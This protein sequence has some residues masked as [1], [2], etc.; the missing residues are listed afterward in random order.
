[1]NNKWHQ[2]DIP[3]K[4][5]T[6]VEVIDIREDE[7]NELETD[8]ETC[9]MCGNEKIRYVHILT[10]KLIKEAFRVGCVCAEKMTNDY[11][12]P[13]KREDE[14]KNCTNRRLNFLNKEWKINSNG[15][16]YLKYVGHYLLIYRDK[17]TDKFK[18]KID[19]VFGNKLF[20][21]LNQ[22]KIATFNGIEHF[23]ETGDWEYKIIKLK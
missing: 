9:M 14:L 3:H 13:K 12:N 20:D 8:Y 18:V 2:Q 22:A 10:H 23:K 21:D 4:A 11:V 6:L 15:N 16:H 17:L 5:W 1:M 7:Q 19:E